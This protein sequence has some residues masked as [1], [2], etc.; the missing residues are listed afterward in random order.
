MTA[1]G[2]HRLPTRSLRTLWLSK[3]H[4]ACDE[5]L[6]AVALLQGGTLRQL[7][8]SQVRPDYHLLCQPASDSCKVV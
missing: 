4:C 8:V 2:L 3:S 1:A 6:E 5:G 7:D